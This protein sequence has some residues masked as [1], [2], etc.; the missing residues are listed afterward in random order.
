MVIQINGYTDRWLKHKWLDGNRWTVK[1]DG[2]MDRQNYRW[3][4]RWLG[5]CIDSLKDGY[6]GG[7][8]DGCVDVSMVGW[9]D[10]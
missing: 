7:Q 9:I 5:I 10:E 4:E 2:Q 8:T 3:L 1:M 6:M